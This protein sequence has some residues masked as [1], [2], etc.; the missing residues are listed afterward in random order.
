MAV[1]TRRGQAPQQPANPLAILP[2]Q[3]AP[4]ARTAEAAAMALERVVTMGDLA[5]LQP[6]ERVAYYLDTCQS[7]GLN[8]R[9][10]PFDWLLL[11]NRVVLYPNKSCA[12]QLRAIHR[13][14][15]ECSV[16]EASKDGSM[17]RCTAKGFMPDGRYDESSKYVPLTGNRQDGSTYRLTGK[18]LANAYMK[19]ETGAKRRVTFSLIGMAAPPQDL[20]DVQYKVLTVDGRG[21]IIDNPTREQR[22][23]AES[24]RMAQVIREPTFEDAHGQPT[25]YAGAADQRP[26]PD[27]G[28]QRRE[29]PAPTFRASE[30]DIRRWCGAWF[31]IVDETP[32]DTKEAR[33]RFVAEFTQDWPQA[34]RTDS[35]RAMFAR[36]E[37]PEAR[38]FLAKIR[39]VVV[40]WKEGQSAEANGEPELGSDV[41]MTPETAAEEIV[42][43]EGARSYEELFPE[44]EVPAGPLRMTEEGHKAAVL[45]GAPPTPTPA[46]TRE[47]EASLERLDA[48]R[49]YSRAEL[50]ALYDAWG[51]RMKA[52]DTTWRPENVKPL[53]DQAL[54]A[55]V[56]ALSAQASDLAAHLAWLE[57]LG[58]EDG[59]DQANEPA[60]F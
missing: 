12:D 30:E 29:G 26:A 59:D 42:R 44:D 20:D 19:A 16:P 17:L 33:A 10:R 45:T 34:K 22:A 27:P 57:T 15:I 32:W 51:A 56:G 2:P 35:M 37:E 9:S 41:G 60:A 28:P 39:A 4:I 23:L 8:P 14:R 21:N 3:S 53:S 24:P 47:E 1:D 50:F 58:D 11:D 52:L 36:C 49:Q 5:A 46:P 55:A 25:V 13:I 31:G 18:N 43:Q 54:R 6:E 48:D 38:D 7:L 40:V